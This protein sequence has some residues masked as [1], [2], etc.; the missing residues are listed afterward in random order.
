MLFLKKSKIEIEWIGWDDGELCC[1]LRFVSKY[2]QILEPT[3]EYFS[4]TYSEFES[5]GKANVSVCSEVRYP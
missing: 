3:F 4:P 2:H 1:L 5:F